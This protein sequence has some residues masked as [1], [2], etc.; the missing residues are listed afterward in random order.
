MK[1]SRTE[2]ILA[3]VM[4][5]T[6]LMSMMLVFAVSGSAEANNEFTLKASELDT[7]PAGDKDNGD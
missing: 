5:F 6:M 7:F 2:R 4:A 1:I 3:I